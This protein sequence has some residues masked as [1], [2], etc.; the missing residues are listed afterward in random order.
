MQSLQKDVQRQEVPDD[1]SACDA[2]EESVQQENQIPLSLQE[3]QENVQILR[4]VRAASDVQTS[5][6]LFEYLL[7][8]LQNFL[9]DIHV[10]PL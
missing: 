4:D 7:G 1:T 2:R 9:R 10:Q 8:R 3:L 5:G 6:I